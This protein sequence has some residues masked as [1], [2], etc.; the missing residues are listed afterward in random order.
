[1]ELK[2]V[3]HCKYLEVFQRELFMVQ[4][5]SRRE[6]PWSN[7]NSTENITL[8]LNIAYSKKLFRCYNCIMCLSDL[9]SKKIRVKVFGKLRNMVC[10][11]ST[12]KM[13]KLKW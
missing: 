13:R 5:K 6:L 3:D 10:W 7:N 9:D 4:G 12:E 11:N 2:D 8:K 1:M